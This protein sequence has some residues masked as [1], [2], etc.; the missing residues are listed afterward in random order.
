[1]RERERAAAEGGEGKKIR[2]SRIG[3]APTK[4]DDLDDD[5]GDNTPVESD[6]EMM[7]GNGGGGG[8]ADGNGGRRKKTA[9]E[10][11]WENGG[12]GVWAPD[13]REQ[14]DLLDP[15][16]RFDAIPQ[17]L[18]GKNIADYFD[19]DI[20]EKLRML[21]EEEDRLQQREQ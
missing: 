5:E 2:K 3:Y 19:P 11:M 8:G 9:R 16:W 17:I 21:E 14:Y 15:E 13:Y 20:E 12:P 4:D 6:N 1:M 18:D 10:L 7:V